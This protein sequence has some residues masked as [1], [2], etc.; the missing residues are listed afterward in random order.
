M[1]P[2]ERLP[3]SSETKLNTKCTE[4]PSTFE[5]SFCEQAPFSYFGKAVAGGKGKD[6]LGNNNR[7]NSVIVEEF[8]FRGKC[9]KNK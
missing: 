2:K 6:H 7:Q 9:C 3:P 1:S 5:F 8:L 4:Y